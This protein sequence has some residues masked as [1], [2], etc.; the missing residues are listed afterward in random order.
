MS[1]RWR[2]VLIAI[3]VVLVAVCIALYWISQNLGPL[4]RGRVVRALEQ[5]FDADVQ[6]KSL[7]ISLIPEA[8]IVA[9][10]IEIRHRGWTDRAPLIAIRRF[11]ADTDLATI[12][13][14]RNRVKYVKLEGL[15]IH[16]P[17]RGASAFKQTFSDGEQIESGEPGRDRTHL[18]F[19]IDT[20]QAD[21]TELVIAPKTPGGNPLEFDLKKLTLH[22]VG[23]GKAMRFMAKLVNAKPPGLIDTNG[24]FGPWQRDDPRATPVSGSYTFRNAN[25][26]VFNG[27]SG[28]LSSSGSYAGVLQHIETS[29]TTDTPD[30][31]LQGGGDT[32][33]LRTKFRA[34]VNGTDGNTIL[35]PVEAAFL[36]S[37]FICR[38]GV[39][40]RPGEKGKMISLQAHTSGAR[41]EDILALVIGGK[42]FLH[43]AVNFQTSF[44]IPPGPADIIDKLRLSGGFR[45][46]SATFANPKI[47]ERLITLSDRARGISKDEE[48]DLKKRGLQPRVASNFRGQ[49]RMEGGRTSFSRL[50]FEVPGAS[51]HL[52]GSY[53]LKS[54]RIDMHGIFQMKATL[55]ETQSGIKSWLIKPFNKLFEKGNA[56]FSAPLEISGTRDHPVI[57]LTVLHH[58][59]TLQ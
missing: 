11:S 13:A 32:V 19:T 16:I 55:S 9:E 1:R 28:I 54:Q 36:Q 42:P 33:H 8:H 14:G 48:E 24:Y 30:F 31:A 17:P 51:I 46:A 15:E 57:G 26:G 29:G 22:S 21:G 59:V 10:G 27:I 38:G 35:D 5:R 37:K 3:G 2:Y 41:M 39:I 34:L 44:V 4:V 23:P 20:I 58:Q 7:Q 56:G 47:E 25:L 53:D 45:V 6:L 40:G 50:A 18:R 52:K 43:G 12:L 49:F